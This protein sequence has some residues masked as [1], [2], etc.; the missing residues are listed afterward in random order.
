MRAH[1]QSLMLWVKTDNSRPHCAKKSKN[2]RK[3]KLNGALSTL[4]ASFVHGKNA[5]SGAHMPKTTNP[6]SGDNLTSVVAD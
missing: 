6:K 2:G 1:S 5:M 4:F 3:Q